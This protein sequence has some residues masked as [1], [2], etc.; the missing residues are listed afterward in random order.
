MDT[1][2]L[3][4]DNA[5][6][7]TKPDKRRTFPSLILY[8]ILVSIF[9]GAISVAVNM[10]TEEVLQLP[11]G[12]LS[13]TAAFLGSI[14]IIAAIAVGI[15]TPLILAFVLIRQR[16]HQKKLMLERLRSSDPYFF[17]LMSDHVKQLVAGSSR[18][19]KIQ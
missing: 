14:A 1:R 15:L 3:P 11:E 7:V 12:K 18:N 10:F 8:S 17:K 6:V 13:G 9:G 5:K 16:N 4:G 19:A 2:K